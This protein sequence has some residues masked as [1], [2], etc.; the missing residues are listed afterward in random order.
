[1]VQLYESARKKQPPQKP[2]TLTIDELD[3]SGTG[4]CSTH[5][6][7]VFVEGA[8]PGEEVRA[9][10]YERKK[11]FW[12]A[13]VEQVL[14]PGAK[15]IAPFCPHF[16]Q[17]GG[18]QHQ[19]IAQL[20]MLEYK[21]QAVDQ[22][23]NKVGGVTALNWQAPLSGSDQGYRRKVRL[24]L[25]ARTGKGKS[26]VHLGFRAQG[27]DKVVDISECKVL[28]PPLQQLLPDLRSLIKGLG[29]VRHIG[30]I[31]LLD[32]D[33]QLQLCLRLTR[34]FP[35]MDRQAL[36][37]FSQEHGC[38]VLLQT[39]A[40]EFEHL[41]SDHQFASYRPVDELSLDFRPT[42][43]IQVNGS[44][45]RAMIAQALNWLDIK[46]GDRV[47]DLFCGVG[48]FALPMAHQGAEVTGIEGVQ[49]MVEQARAN[50]LKNSLQAE[51][52]QAD[53][54]DEDAL[55]QLTTQLGQI[56]KVVLDPARTGAANVMPWLSRLNPAQILYVS[57]NPATFA[58]DM[59]QLVESGWQVDKIGL[60]DM[61]PNTAHTELMALFSR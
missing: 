16:S 34:P 28:T 53:L 1:M 55:T 54:G 59:G 2:L 10:V 15:R 24:A 47:L 4:V 11:R 22:L 57:C 38:T 3:H 61:F 7:V 50:A 18:C 29:C 31:S 5:Q 19:H 9:R 46:P 44:V 32:A 39:E 58:R 30:H 36:K 41:T 60:M 17:C 13:T 56:G 14:K 8:L 25:D 49:V 48:N 21:Q 40:Q 12:R 52:L 37:A 45:N 20:P 23:L 26:S 6:P 27:S 43:F 33:N 35:E 42:D 51:F